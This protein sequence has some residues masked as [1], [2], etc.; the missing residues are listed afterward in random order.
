MPYHNTTKESGASLA[1]KTAR[2]DTQQS[3]V[4][5]F[6]IANPGALKT[7]REVW[8]EFNKQDELT[9]IRRAM[10]D[11]ATDGKLERTEIKKD[12]GRGANNFCWRLARNN[13]KPEQITMF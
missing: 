13:G 4:L 9:S 6:F 3:R 8:A 5:A 7:P 2:A 11:L 1:E 12:G 10:T